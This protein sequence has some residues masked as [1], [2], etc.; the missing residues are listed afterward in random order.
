MG[1]EADNDVW[2]FNT[3]DM[4]DEDMNPELVDLFVNVCICLRFDFLVFVF[5][6]KIGVF[7]KLFRKNHQEVHNKALHIVRPANKISFP[8]TAKV[9]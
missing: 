7:R 9:C 3:L 1:F 8:I 6:H 2:E 5:S 4:H